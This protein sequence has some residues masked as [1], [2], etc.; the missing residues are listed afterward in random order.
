MD[1]HFERELDA[2]EARRQCG[3]EA[4]RRRVEVEFGP[5]PPDEP[6]PARVRRVARASSP[7]DVNAAAELAARV[8]VA[9]EAPEHIIDIRET[10]RP[11]F[12]TMYR[13]NCMC[14][15]RARQSEPTP[16]MARKYWER[17]AG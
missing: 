12:R 5:P 14:G 15:W 11:G 16:L 2:M 4:A 10:H 9:L 17:H 1:E 6:D 8:R 3:L 13:A 7:Q